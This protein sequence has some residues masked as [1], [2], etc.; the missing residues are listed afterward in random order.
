[1]RST[2][3]GARDGVWRNGVDIPLVLNNIHASS[4]KS[5]RKGSGF[6]SK[7]CESTERKHDQP[8][9]GRDESES[10]NDRTSPHDQGRDNEC[11]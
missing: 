5:R 4:S 7:K 2:V 9:S 10:E 1:M 11:I 8:K 6:T 3:K